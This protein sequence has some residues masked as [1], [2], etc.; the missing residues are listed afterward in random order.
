M[1]AESNFA[2]CFRPKGPALSQPRA[3]PWDS[4]VIGSSPKGAILGLDVRNVAPLG[5]KPFN[6]HTQG[7]ALG[8]HSGGPL[9]LSNH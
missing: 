1:N 4:S 8:W 5:L 3:T 2:S 7:V 6:L 9:G